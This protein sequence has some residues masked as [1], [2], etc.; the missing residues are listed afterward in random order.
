MNRK[1][2]PPAS[3]DRRPT[4]RLVIFLSY[5]AEQHDIALLVFNA[6][7]AQGHSVFFDR[8]DLKTGEEVHGA[9]IVAMELADLVVFLISP[10][11]VREKSYCLSELAFAQ[12]KWKNLN[13]R[14]LSVMTVPTPEDQVP[15]IIRAVKYLDPRGNLV[16][17]V[18]Q[19]VREIAF[20]LLPD[21]PVAIQDIEVLRWA[22]EDLKAQ[23]AA[24]SE[25]LTSGFFGSSP[26]HWV[27]C[28]WG[29]LAAFFIW[30]AV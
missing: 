8:S 26:A 2:N 1:L 29:G 10:D 6:L 17:E 22:L 27:T 23:L 11:S 12:K 24:R 30:N 3:S 28:L 25:S 21:R 18:V 4:P 14:L 15:D 13:N 16:A 7:S 20:R 5:A 9:I 19:E